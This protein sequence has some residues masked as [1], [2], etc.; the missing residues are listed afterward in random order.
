MAVT[1]GAKPRKPLGPEDYRLLAEF[2]FLLR[3]FLSFSEAAAE[4]A[5]L[6]AQRH[7]ALLAIKGFDGPMTVGELA[8]RLFIK[9]HSAVGLVDRLVSARLLRRGSDSKDRRRVVLSLTPAAEKLLEGLTAAHREELAALAP[10][11]EPL[12][13]RLKN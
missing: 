4:N 10:L 2:R 9:P 13:S 3:R 8:A 12:L 5:G 6:A 1:G 11:L 7:Q